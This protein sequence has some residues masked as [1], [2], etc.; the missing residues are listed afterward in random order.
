MVA[1][2]AQPW[3]PADATD[4]IREI[5]SGDAKVVLTKHAKDQMANRDLILGDLMYVVKNGFVYDDPEPSTQDGYYKYA[6]ESTT[7]NSNARSLRVIVIPGADENLLKFVTCMWRDE[8][9]QRS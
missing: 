5:A 1:A 7:P 2:K 9:M 6:M 4:T 8:P 3:S